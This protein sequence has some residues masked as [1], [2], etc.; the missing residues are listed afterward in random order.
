MYNKSN[1]ANYSVYSVGDYSLILTNLE[2]I[3]KIF[4]ENLDYIKNKENEFSNSYNKLDRSLYE[5]KLGFEPD[6]NIPKLDL[7]KKFLEKKLFEN[8][9]IKRIDLCYKINEIISLQN[10]IE[11]L[12]ERI[13]RIEFDRSMIEKH[14]EK[15]IK[16][17]N[18]L[19][20]YNCCYCYAETLAQI[21]NKNNV[22][23]KS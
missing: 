7:F 22:K 5:E 2:K 15:R 18:R 6:K 1:V 11:E 3:Y 16:G 17:D 8:Y 19:F 21:K 10:N 4:E 14:E 20:Y 12:D 13:E 23:K 9:D